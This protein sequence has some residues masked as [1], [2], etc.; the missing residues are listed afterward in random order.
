ML[1][2]SR[3]YRDDGKENGNYY[4]RFRV[5][6]SRALFFSLEGR[7]SFLGDS[8]MGFTGNIVFQFGSALVFT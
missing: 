1:G 3:L 6:A 2:T 4:L 5:L 7:K 8:S